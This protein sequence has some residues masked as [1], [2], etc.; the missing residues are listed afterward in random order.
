MTVQMFWK[1]F[2]KAI[3]PNSALLTDPEPVEV[4]SK[5]TK[6]QILVPDL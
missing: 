5:I 4:S 2:F 6:P 3:T 1:H